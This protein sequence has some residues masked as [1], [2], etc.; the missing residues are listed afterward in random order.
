MS[1]ALIFYPLPTDFLSSLPLSAPAAEEMNFLS[2]PND[3]RFYQL[4]FIY[5]SV[6]CEIS[7][8]HFLTSLKGWAV[9]FLISTGT[10]PVLWV[11]EKAAAVSGMASHTEFHDCSI[12]PG[13]SSCSWRCL[14]ILEIPACTTGLEMSS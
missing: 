10:V 5:F 4:F 6:M 2:F 13:A 3:S 11:L 7:V 8:T 12:Q 14:L 1:A 9:S